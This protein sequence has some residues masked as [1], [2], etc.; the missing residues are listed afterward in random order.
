MNTFSRAVYESYVKHVAS[1]TEY[2][3]KKRKEK[4]RKKKG[5]FEFDWATYRKYDIYPHIFLDV[6]A[7]FSERV[8][9]RVIPPAKT[10]NSSESLR[11]FKNYRRIVCIV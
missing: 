7:F 4:K 9:R 5:Y 6:K 2:K 10:R 1:I 8:T 3:E 11:I